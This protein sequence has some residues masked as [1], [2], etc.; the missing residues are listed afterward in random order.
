MTNLRPVHTGL[1]SILTL[2]ELNVAVGTVSR[3]IH[4]NT[5]VFIGFTGTL[6]T[7][8]GSS[9]QILYVQFFYTLLIPKGNHFPFKQSLVYCWTHR[10]SL[11][12]PPGLIW[13]HLVQQFVLRPSL[14]ICHHLKSN[15]WEISHCDSSLCRRRPL[16]SLLSVTTH[17]VDIFPLL[18]NK[19]ILH[20][21]NHLHI[22]RASFW[23]RLH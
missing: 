6:L 9:L 3:N 17:C 10:S 2:L 16:L 1:L 14:S 11:T 4:C 20:Q 22:I 8:F 5:V 21:H 12:V 23:H 19:Q 7:W 13:P 18:Y 15:I